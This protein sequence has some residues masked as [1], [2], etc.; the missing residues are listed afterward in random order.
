MDNITSFQLPTDFIEIDVEEEKP[1]GIWKTLRDQI[2]LQVKKDGVK[3]DA[4][5]PYET[6]Q[7]FTQRAI[8]QIYSDV[9][10]FYSWYFNPEDD[11]TIWVGDKATQNK[12]IYDKP[13]PY[14]N[15]LPKKLR[16]AVKEVVLDNLDAMRE[17]DEIP[18]GQDTTSLEDTVTDNLT[19]YIVN[20][21]SWYYDRKMLEDIENYF[22]QKDFYDSIY[23][24]D[25]YG[26]LG[27]IIDNS[28]FD[29]VTDVPYIAEP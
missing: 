9:T 27:N 19:R 4:I 29:G 7:E 22:E 11:R 20:W 17:A 25:N 15:E 18:A 23:D 6:K 1:V 14:K 12:D 24:E 21:T 26:A 3:E 2:E 16:E 8:D 5:Q 28:Q 13:I 10:E